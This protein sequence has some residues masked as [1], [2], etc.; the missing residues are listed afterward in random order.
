[1]ERIPT[2]ERTREKLR[3]LM[4]GRSEVADG[5]SELVRLAA[6]LIIEEALE[7]EAGDALGR[8]HYARGA[9]PGA[10]Y[11]NGYRTGRVKSAE[12]AIDYSAPQIGDLSETVPLAHSRG[13]A[14]PDGGAGS[15]G[16]GDVCTRAFDA[17]HRSAVCR[18]ERCKPAQPH[19]RGM[20]AALAPPALPG[21][22][23]EK[24]AKQ[25][26]RGSLAGVQGPQYGLLQSAL[27]GPGAP[28]ARRHCSDLARDLPSAVACLDDDFEEQAALSP[29][30]WR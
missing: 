4:E 28:A 15:P 23:D 27:G 2:S 11:R 6:R 25:S 22:Q 26:A 3:A 7:G 1:M 5:R 17:R 13:D 10:G 16:G 14:G 30:P 29:R 19:D 12:G 8:D 24:P 18:Q 20:L 21:A 9:A